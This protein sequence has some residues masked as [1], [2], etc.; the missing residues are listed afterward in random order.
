MGQIPSNLQSQ[1]LSSQISLNSPRRVSGGEGLEGA[2]VAM[3]NT[4]VHPAAY[5]TYE[6]HDSDNLSISGLELSPNNQDTGQPSN[7]DV[8]QRVLVT[9][10]TSPSDPRRRASSSQVEGLGNPRRLPLSPGGSMNGRYHNHR[11]QAPDPLGG[12]LS[13]GFTAINSMQYGVPPLDTP[14]PQEFLPYRGPPIPTKPNRNFQKPLPPLNL[15]INE[16]SSVNRFDP[17]DYPK[18]IP[19]TPS[20][21][22]PVSPVT[23]GIRPEMSIMEPPDY[24]VRPGESEI[25]KDGFRIMCVSLCSKSLVTLSI[26]YR[27]NSDRNILASDGCDANS[28]W[29]ECVIRIFKNSVGDLRILTLRE[30]SVDQR[31]SKSDGFLK[32]YRD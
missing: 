14:R 8:N 16:S 2:P 24:G 26:A 28:R 22:G 27:G 21:N 20:Y 5:N 25:M 19:G 10:P 1:G 17:R 9:P 13:R 4:T 31:H 30:G 15:P 23:P 32:R 7:S 6:S 29:D 3:N 18:T 12:G 11:T